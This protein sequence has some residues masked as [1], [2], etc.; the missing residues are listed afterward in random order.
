MPCF[1]KKLEAS[2]SDFANEDQ[3][4]DV[5]CVLTAGEVLDILKEKNIE[6]PSLAE[7][8]INEMYVNVLVLLHLAKS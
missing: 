7:A 6:L 5:D 2:R 1:D 4:R 3:V 8:A